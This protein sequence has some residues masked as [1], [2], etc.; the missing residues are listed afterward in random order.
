MSPTRSVPE[1]ANYFYNRL[2]SQIVAV[3]ARFGNKFQNGD[4]RSYLLYMFV[5]VLLILT[6]LAVAL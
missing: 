1:L 2:V 3:S 4:V 6:L 5:I